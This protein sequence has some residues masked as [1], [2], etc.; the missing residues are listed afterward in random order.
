[1]VFVSFYG[2][3]LGLEV[4]KNPALIAA[5]GKKIINMICTH[6]NNIAVY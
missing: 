2:P 1:M 4:E 5:S 6:G 3:A